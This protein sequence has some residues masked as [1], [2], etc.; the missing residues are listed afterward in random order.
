MPLR[1]VRAD[2][3]GAL[4]DLDGGTGL[5]D[6]HADVRARLLAVT[7]HVSE[8]RTEHFRRAPHDGVPERLSTA[9]AGQIDVGGEILQELLTNSVAAGLVGPPSPFGSTSWR[10]SAFPT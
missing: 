9:E 10:R 7:R 8:V 3:Q 5:S 1:R 6:Q 2:D 4:R